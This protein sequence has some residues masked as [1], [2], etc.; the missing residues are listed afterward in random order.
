NSALARYLSM[1]LYRTEG[2]I[3]DARIDKEKIKEAWKLQAHL[4]NFPKPEIDEYLKDTAEAKLDLMVFTGRAPD[5]K[6]NTLY[7]HT[8]KDLLIISTSAENPV[9]K[10]DLE[11]LNIIAWPGIKKG[12]HFKFQLPYLEKQDSSVDRVELWI[13]GE[14]ITKLRTIESIENV[15]IQTFEVKKPLIYLKTIVRTVSKGLLS[16][17][18][19][20]EMDDSI[21]NPLLGFATRLGTDLAVDATENADLRISHFFPKLALA[22]E[23]HLEPGCYNITIKYI[24]K[25]N[26]VIYQ[27]TK[28][29]FQIRKNDLNLVESFYLN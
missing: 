29:E 16:A 21:K 17:S 8:E 20:R 25:N 28:E 2:K 9:G 19:K 23:I 10:Q 7:I 13:D 4:Y 27:D 14:K 15:A 6:A 3:D 22:G 12:Y 11:T 24:G 18:A 26:T 1:L 5:K